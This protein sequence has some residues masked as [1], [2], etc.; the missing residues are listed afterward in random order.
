MA[1]KDVEAVRRGSIRYLDD[2]KAW[3]AYTKMKTAQRRTFGS[4]MKLL[5]GRVE[6]AASIKVDGT[7]GPA[8]DHVL[9]VNG[10]YDARCDQLLAE[11]AAAHAPPPPLQMY[12][13]FPEG[14]AGGVCQR[15][16]RT[17]GD[18]HAGFAENWALDFCAG[19][20]TP[21]VAVENGIVTKL[22]GHPPWED[23]WDA[24]GVFGLSIHFIT[25]AGYHYYLTHLGKRT[26]WEGLHVMAG[27]IIG[28][29]GDQ[30]FRPDHVHYGVTSPKGAADAKVH[31][32]KVSKSPRI[33]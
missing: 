14:W 4:G 26:V 10:G 17:A 13:P 31:I 18:A 1:G 30:H 28:Y 8:V 24:Q 33:H 9:R 7:A 23:T 19:P 20:K 11:Y 16:H 25:P 22:S 5:V 32:T 6:K 15:F 27:D 12:Y 3:K 29:V 21:V 2:D